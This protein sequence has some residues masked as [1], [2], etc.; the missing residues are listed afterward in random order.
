MPGANGINKMIELLFKMMFQDILLDL[1]K[2]VPDHFKR[3]EMYNEAVRNNPYMLRH[4]PDHFKT[5]EMCDKAVEIDPFILWSVRDWYKTQEMCDK[6]V[7]KVSWSLEYVP[8]WF[9]TQGQIKLW[10]DDNDYCN[11]D[12]LIKWYED[13]KKMKGLKSFNKRRVNAYCLAS[14]KILGLVYVRR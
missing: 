10:R 14:I 4:V 5:Q 6:T 8:D 11:D 13:Y 7:E 1:M 2:Y 12:R 9:V 3:K